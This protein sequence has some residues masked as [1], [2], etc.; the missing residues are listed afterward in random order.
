MVG[1]DIID[2]NE[3]RRSSN[4][5]RPGFVQKI[6]TAKEQSIIRDSIDPF[7]TVWHLWSMK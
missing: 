2:L 6:F 5:E 3:A 4:W 1:N 7:T